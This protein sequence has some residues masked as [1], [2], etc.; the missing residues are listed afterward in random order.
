[1][2][3]VKRVVV[4]GW[5]GVIDGPRNEVDASATIDRAYFDFEGEFQC[6]CRRYIT[7]SVFL[8]INIPPEKK[9]KR[10]S[11]VAV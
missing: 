10:L 11:K 9:T 7:S 3:R 8:P 5:G 4:G 6:C 1:M 2:L